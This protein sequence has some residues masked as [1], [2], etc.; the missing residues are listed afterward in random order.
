M[1]IW[2][3]DEV[4]HTDIRLHAGLWREQTHTMAHNLCCKMRTPHRWTHLTAEEDLEAW[5]KNSI[6][7][8]NKTE[9]TSTCMRGTWCN[10]IWCKRTD[11]RMQRLALTPALV[12]TFINTRTH[13]MI[14]RGNA[15]RPE[16]M[17]ECKF[18]VY[19]HICV[20]LCGCLPQGSPRHRAH[21]SESARP[22]PLQGSLVS[23]ER[24]LPVLAATQFP[25]TSDRLHPPWT[26]C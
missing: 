16:L 22:P 24:R 21:L 6:F 18:I 9:S 15:V 19:M 14:R 10:V 2:T 7:T 11:E 8:W 4:S 17:N 1:L 3:N 26:W 20:Y 5:Y 25:P 13:W 23:A 12:E